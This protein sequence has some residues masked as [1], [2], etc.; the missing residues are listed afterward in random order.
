[1][2]PLVTI[3]C[4]TN[5]PECAEWLAWNVSKQTYVHTEVLLITPLADYR[6][7]LWFFH[8]YRRLSHREGPCGELRNLVLEYARGEYLVWFDDDDWQHPQ[9]IEWLVEAMEQTSEPWAGWDR[10]YCYD[11]MRDGAFG[12]RQGVKKA[13]RVINGATIYRT[14][15]V[16]D[17]PY[18]EDVKMASDGLWIASLMEKHSTFGYR[19]IDDR[20]HAIWMRHDGNTCPTLRDARMDLTLQ[21]LADKVG[22]DAWA[23]TDRRFRALAEV[24]RV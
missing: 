15:A 1:M 5:R 22:K 16:R 10:G 2:P 23:D 4:V 6:D 8:T 13:S 11:L 19:L 20:V 14:D 21:A 18:R 24:L 3:G 7:D 9:R 12:L 17:V